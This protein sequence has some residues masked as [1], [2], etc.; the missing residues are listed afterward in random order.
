MP[1]L[2][3]SPAADSANVIAIDA[4]VLAV[5]IYTT[6]AGEM[7]AKSCAPFSFRPLCVASVASVVVVT[8]IVIVYAPC[9]LT[10]SVA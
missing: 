1:S 10:Y 8:I 9:M 6:T 5:V 2:P 4:F 7:A 3:L